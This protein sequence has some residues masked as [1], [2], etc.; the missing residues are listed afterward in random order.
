MKNEFEDLLS[1]KEHIIGLYDIDTRCL[2]R[3][4]REKGV[5]N[6]MITVTDSLDREDAVAKIA[7]FIFPCTVGLSGCICQPQ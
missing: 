5:M 4:I 6:G 7:S 2:T 3:I 1:K